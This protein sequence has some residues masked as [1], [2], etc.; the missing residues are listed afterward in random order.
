[1]N[2]GIDP[3]GGERRSLGKSMVDQERKSNTY[4]LHIREPVQ[5]VDDIN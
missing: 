4:L 1:L 2:Y 3:N 5:V